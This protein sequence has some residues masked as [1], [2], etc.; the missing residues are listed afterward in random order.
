MEL[1]P[2]NRG[3]VKITKENEEFV[4]ILQKTLPGM[5]RPDGGFDYSAIEM[6]LNLFDIVG[7]ERQYLFDKF[8]NIISVIQ[9]KRQQKQDGGSAR[10]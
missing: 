3:P 9:E 4:L 5:T 1:C 2:Q 8:L 10:T 6:I 7:D